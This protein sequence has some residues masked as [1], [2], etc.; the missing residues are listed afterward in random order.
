MAMP[1]VEVRGVQGEGG[2]R[3]GRK[4]RGHAE[5]LEA[6]R[7]PVVRHVVEGLGRELLREL[8]ELRGV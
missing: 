2:L 5:Q 6:M 8:L 1:E 4:R 7:E 3:S